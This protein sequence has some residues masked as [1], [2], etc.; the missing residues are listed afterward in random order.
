[1]GLQ[2]NSK[3]KTAVL[4]CL[5]L[6]ASTNHAAF[7][8]TSLPG[9][10]QAVPYPNPG[11]AAASPTKKVVAVAEFENKTNYT[12]QLNLGYGMADMLAD[13]LIKSGRFTVL[14]R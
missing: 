12:G 8:Q 6:F 13:A 1:M 9:L 4:F 5:M 11:M 2:K 3:L 7:T 10:P 14:E